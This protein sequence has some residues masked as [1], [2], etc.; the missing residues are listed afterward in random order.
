[1]TLPGTRKGRTIGTTWNAIGDAD[2]KYN[3]ERQI[4]I[5]TAP[6]KFRA[7]RAMQLRLAPYRTPRTLRDVS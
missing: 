2:S 6:M 3:G 1:M 4:E 7:M 5:P